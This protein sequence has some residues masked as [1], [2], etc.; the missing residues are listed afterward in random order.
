METQLT[1]SATTAVRLKTAEGIWLADLAAQ[2]AAHLHVRLWY[3]N[4]DD[5]P[6][7]AIG[8]AI[9]CSLTRDEN[10][11][12]AAA[13]VLKQ[14][15]PDIWLGVPPMWTSAEKRRS[16]RLS[17]DFPV[18][19]IFGNKTGQAI[20][21][22]FGAGSLKILS[23]EPIGLWKRLTLTFSLPGEP[24]PTTLEGVVIHESAGDESGY[25]IGIKFSKVTPTEGVHL[26]RAIY[27]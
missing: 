14:E 25:E 6:H 23:T 22:D 15:G 4:P 21:R 12:H 2:G 7:W 3:H 8:S 9:D 16:E 10:S 27:G 18:S 1:V 17:A 11:Y 20:V 24:M 19:Y 26:A 13:T 5:A